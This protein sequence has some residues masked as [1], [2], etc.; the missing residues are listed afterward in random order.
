MLTP[1]PVD[2]IDLGGRPRLEPDREHQRYLERSEAKTASAGTEA[3]LCARS[4]SSAA[5]DSLNAQ[6]SASMA[7]SSTTVP[8]GSDVGSSSW[9]LPLRTTARMGKR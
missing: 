5:S 8:S 2:A 6:P 9:S 4:R 7:S 3:L 1:P